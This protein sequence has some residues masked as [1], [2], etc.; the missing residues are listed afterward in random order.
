MISCRIS[1]E[2]RDEDI[3]KAVFHSVSPDN[4]G[5]VKAELHGIKV[6]FEISGDS[7][8]SL[9]HTVNDL[10]SCVRAAEKSMEM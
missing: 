1:L 2:Y 6:V 5:Y 7:A 3:A 9:S 10:L 4:E 8:L